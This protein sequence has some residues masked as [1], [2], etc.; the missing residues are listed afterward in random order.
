MSHP[1]LTSALAK[2]E[3][4]PMT[5]DDLKHS[6]DTTLR[7][8]WLLMVQLARAE[9]NVRTRIRYDVGNYSKAVDRLDEGATEVEYIRGD[10]FVTLIQNIAARD[11]LVAL[12]DDA[13]GTYAYLNKL[14]TYRED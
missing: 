11:A 7:V 6:E 10:N 2:Y 8:I 1:V 4:P 12:L 13:L 14:G 5:I 9:A 3:L